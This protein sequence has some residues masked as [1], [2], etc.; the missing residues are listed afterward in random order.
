VFG[1][2][3]A[4]SERRATKQKRIGDAAEVNA[5]LANWPLQPVHVLNGG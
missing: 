2:K 5:A 1:M 4:V 3:K